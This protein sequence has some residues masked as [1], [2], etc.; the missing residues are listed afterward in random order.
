ME[1]TLMAI[2]AA[3]MYL[4]FRVAHR[5]DGTLIVERSI[6]AAAYFRCLPHVPTLRCY[7]LLSFARLLPSAFR[8]SLLLFATLCS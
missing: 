5:L 1:W 6:I 4:S 8:Y 3:D 7:L 2:L